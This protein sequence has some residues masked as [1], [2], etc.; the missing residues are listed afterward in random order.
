MA[1]A[2]YNLQTTIK[3]D[4]RQHSVAAIIWF[5]TTNCGNPGQDLAFLTICDKLISIYFC[6][7][8]PGK[9]KLSF[10]DDLNCLSIPKAWCSVI[11]G[12]FD[13]VY[14]YKLIHCSYQYNNINLNHDDVIK[15][16]HFPR[17]WSL[18]W[19]IH[20]SPVNSPHKGQ[21]REALMF[22]LICARINGWINYGEA[23]DLRRHRIHCDAIVTTYRFSCKVSI[24]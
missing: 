6:F 20:W 8:V 1:D 14:M 22:F 3:V 13:E 9:L 12:A 24:N 2:P 18:V 15:W 17:Y 5:W 19:R 4:L 21:W 16:K 10:T 23:G 11:T 7:S